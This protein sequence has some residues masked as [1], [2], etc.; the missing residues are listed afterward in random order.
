M[1]KIIFVASALLVLSLI[2]IGGGCF[3]KSP[4][5]FYK[6]VCK[7]GIPFTERADDAF[8]TGSSGIF[9]EEYDDDEI[10]D[11]VEDMVEQ[12]EDI[13]ED[14]ED[15]EDDDVCDEVIKNYRVAS[16]K[17]LT[18]EG[19]KIMFSMNCMGYVAMK[20]FDEVN[21]CMEDVDEVCNPLPK[22]F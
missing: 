8:D 10:D 22:S 13:R 6:K 20:D 9:G 21:D 12:E 1:K 5:S 2:L 17:M 3:Q 16:T 15:D 19:C 7:A 14:C 11:C 4:E 18:R